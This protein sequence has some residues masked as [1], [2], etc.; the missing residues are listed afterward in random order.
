[1]IR[2]RVHPFVVLFTL[3]ALLTP[4]IA[5]AG[6]A[7]DAL[8]VQTRTE[9]AYGYR[10]W[11][12]EAT[13]D[14]FGVSCSVGDW[15]SRIQSPGEPPTV[16]PDSASGGYVRA[17]R[18]STEIL[19]GRMM[20][21]H[22]SVWVDIPYGDG[23]YLLKSSDGARLY[24][25]GTARYLDSIF[26]PATGAFERWEW[27]EGPVSL[28]LSVDATPGRYSVD[29]AAAPPAPNMGVNANGANQAMGT[30]AE[31]SGY[32]VDMYG[33]Q[34]MA[35]PGEGYVLSTDESY[36]LKSVGHTNWVPGAA[37]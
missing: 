14:T 28:A 35:D 31:F 36:V 33:F 11:T 26:D 4:S 3:L 8:H 24:H 5:L 6:E 16:V 2:G 21:V 30:P 10:Y 18:W 25:V 32:L 34:W 9:T 7:P 22:R 23:A 37:E 20:D 29:H 12:N 15:V 19:D 17:Y 13:G 1:V 27:S